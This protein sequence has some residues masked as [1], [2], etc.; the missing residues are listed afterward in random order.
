MGRAPRG[1]YPPSPSA[2]GGAPEL[3]E[4]GEAPAEEAEPAGPGEGPPAR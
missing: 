4:A 1:A 2:A 3:A